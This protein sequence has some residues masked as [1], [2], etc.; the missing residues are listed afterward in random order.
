VSDSLDEAF[1]DYRISGIA[2][3]AIIITI[4]SGIIGTVGMSA[5]G[6]RIIFLAAWTYL[7]PLTLGLFHQYVHYIAN[8]H[9]AHKQ[10]GWKWDDFL[11]KRTGFQVMERKP[12]VASPDPDNYFGIA[13]KA[14]VWTFSTF[15]SSLI[16]MATILIGKEL[17]HRYLSIFPTVVKWALFV[18]EYCVILKMANKYLPKPAII[19]E[20]S[21]IE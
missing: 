10:L 13:D 5:H 19:S 16:L 7:L 1:K 3:T 9:S 15:L 8:Q 11:K 20:P 2:L 21:I 4:S 12:D 6:S 14:C 18:I 17:G